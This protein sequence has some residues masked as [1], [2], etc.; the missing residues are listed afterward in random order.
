[1]INWAMIPARASFRNHY[2]EDMQEVFVIMTGSVEIVVGEAIAV[3]DRG[4]AVV[5]EPGEPHTMRN[6]TD[7]PV[8]YLALGISEGKGGRTV[9]L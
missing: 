8:E 9:V 6:L 3:L 5:I 7:A 1:M 4:D 2:H